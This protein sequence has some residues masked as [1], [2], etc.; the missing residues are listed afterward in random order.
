M[1]K[2]QYILLSLF[3]IVSCGSSSSY[4]ST[5]LVEDSSSDNAA[6][7]LVGAPKWTSDP[8]TNQ[9]V[10]IG[11]SRDLAFSRTKAD[12][13]GK[14]KLASSISQRI[15]S[16]TDGAAKETS[17]AFGREVSQGIQITVNEFVQGLITDKYYLC[18]K[19]VMGVEG[20]QSFA[21]LEVDIDE[22][23]AIVRDEL[24]RQKRES[25]SKEYGNF[26]D[27]VSDRISSAFE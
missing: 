1:I 21:L 6:N 20:Y 17:A 19:M 8:G 27:D 13:D 9:A 4:V 12:T 22:A 3:F 16:V 14:E 25:T 18:P 7:C 23:V 26:L 11:E 2:Q 5:T 24:D 15:K 10:G